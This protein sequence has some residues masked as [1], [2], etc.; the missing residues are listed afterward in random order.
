MQKDAETQEMDDTEPQSPLVACHAWPVN[1]KAL[2][3]ESTDAQY[4]VGAQP[5]ASSPVAPSSVAGADQPCP[6]HEVI[7]LAAVA[8][9]MH[10]DGSAHDTER[11]PGPSA[12]PVAGVGPDHVEPSNR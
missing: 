4:P 9:A 6:F 8:T 3:S 12:W 7:W 2:P 11:E 10:E 5:T 1:A